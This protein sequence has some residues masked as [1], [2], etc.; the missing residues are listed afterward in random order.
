[1]PGI[2]V[3]IGLD[4][5]VVKVY[6]VAL[7]QRRTDPPSPRRTVQ[8]LASLLVLRKQQRM[9]ATWQSRGRALGHVSR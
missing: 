3:K 8:R 1:M 9:P 5:G 7:A 6:S 2:G 4:S